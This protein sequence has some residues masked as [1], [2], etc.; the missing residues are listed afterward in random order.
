[1]P[2]SHLYRVVKRW[3]PFIPSAVHT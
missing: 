1:M 2:Y 3:A